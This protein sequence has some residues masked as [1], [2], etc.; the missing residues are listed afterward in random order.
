MNIEIDYTASMNGKSIEIVI[1]I[2]IDNSKII[3]H[4]L[5]NFDQVI[6]HRTIK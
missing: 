3:K 2:Y 5:V 4:I 1:C 6:Y